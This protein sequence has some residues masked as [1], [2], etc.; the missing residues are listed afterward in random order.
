MT[1]NPFT[2]PTTA[3][4]LSNKAAA[5]ILA[6]ARPIF[7]SWEWLRLAYNVCLVMIVLAF[8]SLSFPEVLLLPEFWVTCVVGAVVSNVCFF[9]GPIAECYI[10]WLGFSGQLVRWMMFLAGLVFTSITAV[11][12]IGSMASSWLT[13]PM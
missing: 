4:G 11:V 5:S 2:S 12:A 1:Q 8:T 10:T 6:I 3:P 13:N 7:I 9:I